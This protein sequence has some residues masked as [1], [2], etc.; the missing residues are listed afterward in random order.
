MRRRLIIAL[1]ALLPVLAVVN[2]AAAFQSGEISLVTQRGRFIIT[3]EIAATGEERAQGLQHRMSMA[4]GSGMLFDF[5]SPQPVS[6]WM[7]NTPIP[8]DMVFVGSNGRV[9]NI[10]T[11]TTPYSLRSISAAG[12]VRWVLELN[13]GAAKSM[14]VTA[15]DRLEFED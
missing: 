10:E 14:G 4:T 13:A 11:N 7:K 9:I 8:L 2:Y 1:F 5:I 3:V 12:P 6:M 15:G